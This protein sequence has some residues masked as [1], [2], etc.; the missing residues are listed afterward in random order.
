MKRHSLLE[1]VFES[2][3]FSCRFLVIFAVIGSLIAA[4]VLFLK[5]S[6]EIV[7]GVTSFL[8]IITNFSPT[9]TDDKT[10]I[11]AF[12]PAIDNYLFATVLLIF[13][14]GIYELFIS[15]IDPSLRKPF[16]RPNWLNIATL[17]D[18]KTHI[19]EVVV[20]IL[21]INFFQ[22]SFT[23]SL[24]RPVDLLYLGGGILLISVSLFIT[25]KIIAHRAIHHAAH[26][27]N[28]VKHTEPPI[29]GGNE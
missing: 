29:Q 9:D 21:I 19:S 12:I 14:M 13:S 27:P 8:H 10:V 7:Q 20:M 23:V 5:G 22:F 17:D 1:E 18:L 15:E 26:K 24:N 25:H 16:S 2:A 4:L 11:L 28:P 3:L 6:L